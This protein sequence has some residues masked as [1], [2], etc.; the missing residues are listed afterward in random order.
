M[1]H[2]APV[3]MLWIASLAVALVTT[4]ST[5]ALTLLS[6]MAW[7]LGLSILGYCLGRR[8]V[9]GDLGGRRGTQ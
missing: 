8:S 1:R 5:D 4:P 9:R 7:F 2:V 3:A 6:T